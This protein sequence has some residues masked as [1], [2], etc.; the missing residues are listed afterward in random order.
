MGANDRERPPRDPSC[1]E[2][3]SARG[4]REEQRDED[5]GPAQAARRALAA[6]SDE[7]C[8]R[9][10]AARR[11]LRRRRAR[12]L[13]VLRAA[14]GSRSRNPPRLHRHGRPHAGEIEPS[15]LRCRG[16]TRAV[17]DRRG[18]LRVRRGRSALTGV[19]ETIRPGSTR[20]RRAGSR[21]GRLDALR[22][23]RHRRDGSRGRRRHGR[24]SRG[25][26]RS[27]SWS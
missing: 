8:V 2:T 17:S 5:P 20:S 7:V 23:R 18:R 25:G 21:D 4:E 10:D 24:R 15:D 1:S 16:D 3:A 22:R 26:S 6:R 9:H 14:H 19:R 12:H 11:L 27:R 13:H